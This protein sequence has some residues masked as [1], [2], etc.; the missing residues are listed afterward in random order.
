MSE[1][2]R[3]SQRELVIRE[4]QRIEQEFRDRVAAESV[5]EAEKEAV[6]EHAREALLD[7]RLEEQLAGEQVQGL[8]STVV[9]PGAAA[10]TV[11]DIG[12]GVGF[13]VGA[14]VDEMGQAGLEAWG[15]IG[16]MFGATPREREDFRWLRDKFWEP[17]G[18]AGQAAQGITQFLTLFLPAFGAAGAGIRVAGKGARLAG[19]GARAAGVSAKAVGDVGKAARRVAHSPVAK[20]MGAGAVADSLAFDPHEEGLAALVN[21]IPELDPVI[22]D[23]IALRDETEASIVGRVKNATEGVVLGGVAEVLGRAIHRWVQVKREGRPETGITEV[24]KGRSDLRQPMRISANASERMRGDP[25]HQA[26]IIEQLKAAKVSWPEFIGRKLDYD[27]AYWSSGRY[28]PREKL[29]AKL[30]E[31]EWLRISEIMRKSGGATP[32][33]LT[34]DDLVDMPDEFDEAVTYP[35]EDDT[36]EPA[37]AGGDEPDSFEGEP[38]PDA[39]PGDI[40]AWGGVA[41]ETPK[42]TKAPKQT[43]EERIEELRS[44]VKIAAGRLKE[45]PSEWLSMMSELTEASPEMAGRMR[46]AVLPVAFDGL[47]GDEWGALATAMQNE[48]VKLS[49]SDRRRIL[50]SIPDQVGTDKTPAVG[51]DQERFD[52]ALSDAEGDVTVE[53]RWGIEAGWRSLAQMI[54]EWVKLNPETPS[55]T[56]WL[57][58]DGEL[59]LPETGPAG[60]LHSGMAFEQLVP[61]P[62]RG[63]VTNDRIRAG[64][65]PWRSTAEQDQASLKELSKKRTEWYGDLVKS[66]DYPDESII[67]M[68]NAQASQTLARLIHD[69]VPWSGGAGNVLA[70]QALEPDADTLTGAKLDML[71]IAGQQVHLQGVRATGGELAD[72]ANFGRAILRYQQLG[73][74][75]AEDTDGS[76]RLRKAQLDLDDGQVIEMFGGARRLRALG[77]AMSGQVT[78]NERF[79]RLTSKQVEEG[80]PPLTLDRI[81]SGDLDADVAEQTNRPEAVDLAEAL[82]LSGAYVEANRIG[83]PQRL[84]AVDAIESINTIRMS[85]MLS[86]PYTHVRNAVGNSLPLLFELPEQLL[87]SGIQIASN[88]ASWADFLAENWARGAGMAFGARQGM[89]LMS[90]DLERAW[91]GSEQGPRWRRA[92]EL[93]YSE[94]VEDFSK[95]RSYEPFREG[96]KVIGEEWMS[97]PPSWWMP[98]GKLENSALVQTPFR[99]LQVADM[100]F[101]SMH[102]ASERFVLAAQRARKEGLRGAALKERVETDVSQVFN[103]WEEV[104]SD[105]HLVALQHARERTFTQDLGPMA[106]RFNDMLNAGGGIGRLL[107]PFPRTLMNLTHYTARRIPGVSAFYKDFRQNWREGGEKRAREMARMATGSAFIGAGFL[108]AERG[109]VTGNYEG[110]QWTR[111]PW[112]RNSIRPPFSDTWIRH[113]FIPFGGFALT[114]GADIAT[115]VHAAETSDERELASGLALAA[116]RAVGMYME[117]HPIAGLN[118]IVDV[119]FNSVQDPE[120]AFRN[121]QRLG[122]N[123]ASTVV[124]L[125]GARRDLVKLLYGGIGAERRPGGGRMNQNESWDE[126]FSEWWTETMRVAFPEF[127]ALGGQYPRRDLYGEPIGAPAFDPVDWRGERIQ[128]P[129]VWSSLLSPTAAVAAKD[130]PLSQE[131]WRVAPLLSWRNTPRDRSWPVRDGIEGIEYTDAEYDRLSVLYGQR[132]KSEATRLVGTKGYQ[133]RTDE[134]RAALLTETRQASLRWASDVL[135]A[136]DDALRERWVQAKLRG[137]R[138]R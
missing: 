103:G 83:M 51:F 22:S 87:T 105:D 126:A 91:Y 95:N 92:T 24:M 97:A 118:D 16:E 30:K 71:L 113:D 104:T 72:A 42:Q 61:T 108:A 129:S 37:P 33:P 127:R 137:E 9:E 29:A 26:N 77:Y 110:N 44:K 12:R 111:M 56:D 102:Y 73:R 89:K 14:A 94:L 62:W 79:N 11:T 124:P 81:D 78:R 93:G 31:E 4:G 114:M 6:R 136:R 59:F 80:M 39:G 46:S 53:G 134:D 90:A 117:E 49:P 84:K 20:G 18:M 120:S 55:V 64:Y 63:G 96:Q 17:R 107:V 38:D 131:I 121:L 23:W 106:Q 85:S 21:S 47:D 10:E 112:P 75:F 130:D 99:A 7:R 8:T 34:A 66:M 60:G 43:R 133:Q 3:E 69:T 116:A 76:L 88:E 138:R 74:E 1:Y 41:D 122:G 50:L 52:R 28:T 48:I 15:F 27:W 123:I 135:L 109:N 45:E 100:M 58:G 40:S 115:A 13:G 125:H 68:R 32:S 5:Q 2:L 82:R 119:A 57:L 19:E 65:L 70:R 101:K 128:L 98:S 25:R 132:F 86:S 54:P 67:G 35:K 36:F